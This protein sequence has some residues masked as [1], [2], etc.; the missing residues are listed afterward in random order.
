MKKPQY[1][2]RETKILKKKKKS[3]NEEAEDSKRNHK[4]KY[5]KI[6]LSK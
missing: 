1:S 3:T 2:Q 6:D 4:I 5:L